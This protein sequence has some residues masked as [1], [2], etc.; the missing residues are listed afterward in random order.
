MIKYIFSCV[1]HKSIKFNDKFIAVAFNAR[2]ILVRS[3][4]CRS[5]EVNFVA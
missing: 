1:H 4:G 3:S 5:M 2:Q